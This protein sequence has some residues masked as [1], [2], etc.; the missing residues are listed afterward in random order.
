MKRKAW[1]CSRNDRGLDNRMNER[2]KSKYK[3]LPLNTVELQKRVAR[4]LKISSEETMKICEALYQKGFIRYEPTPS[5]IGSYPR[6]ETAVFAAGTDFQS[7]IQVQSGANDWGTYAQKLL[8]G[9]FAPPRAGKGDDHAHP[10]IHPTKLLERVS[11]GSIGSGF[12]ASRVFAIYEY[13][14]RHFLASCSRDSVLSETGRIGGGLRSRAA[15]GDRHGAVYRE[16]DDY[17]GA[18]LSGRVQIRAVEREHAAVVRS[19]RGSGG[20]EFV[21]GGKHHRRISLIGWLLIGSGAAF[22]AGTHRVDGQ[23][24]DRDRRDDLGAHRHDPEPRLREENADESVHADEYRPGVGGD[25]HVPAVPAVQAVSPRPHG[26]R[27]HGDQRGEGALPGG[28]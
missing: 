7:L 24:G 2:K 16:R 13:I 4:H 9:E 6:T 21:C 8:N 27:M 10:P 20:C 11:A 5:L 22:R 15:S 12:D 23:R 14:T 26:A 28:D 19:R 18:E 3:P 25:V 17:S 1:Y